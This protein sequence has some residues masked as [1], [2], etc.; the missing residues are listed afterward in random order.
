VELYLGGSGYEEVSRI[1]V[2]GSGYAFVAGQTDSSDFPITNPIQPT[3]NGSGDAFVTKLTPTGSTLVYSTYLGGIYFDAGRGIVIDSSGQAYIVG[4]TY[5]PDFPTVNPV[6]PSFGGYV[7]AFVMKISDE[8][9][10]PVRCETILTSWTK[11]CRLLK[12]MRSEVY[13]NISRDVV[14]DDQLLDYIDQNQNTMEAL[15]SQI[16]YGW[17]LKRF[18][19]FDTNSIAKQE[20]E[21]FRLLAKA[22][23][24]IEVLGL[25]SEFLFRIG[26]NTAFGVVSA[27]IEVLT[28]II[29]GLSI[30]RLSVGAYTL[31]TTRTLLQYYIDDRLPLNLQGGKTKEVS[32]QN[33]QNDFGDSLLQISKRTRIP[34]D[35][36]D[37]W[38]ENAFMAVRLVRYADSEDIRHEQGLAIADLAVQIQ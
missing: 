38:F 32:W 28:P 1:A 18:L 10:S 27:S 8:M 33:L 7:D 5:S 12:N 37:E 25:I 14:S 9:P 4:E 35:N 6:Q 24:I 13:F 34:M 26:Y 36:L 19:E 31:L 29:D 20:K 22:S 3:L 15:L 23:D 16:D 21:F 17:E 11:N 2:D 30:Y